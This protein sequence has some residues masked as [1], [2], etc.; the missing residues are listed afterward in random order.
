[1]NYDSLSHFV[2]GIHVA[3]VTHDGRQAK[4]EAIR[5]AMSAGSTVQP[6]L[7]REPDNPADPRAIAI[8]IVANCVRR[9]VGFLPAKLACDLSPLMDAGLEPVTVYA[10][11]VIGG[12]LEKPTLGMII[13]LAAR[14]PQAQEA[15][16]RFYYETHY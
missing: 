15:L 13:R 6:I 3:G 5:A 11:L 4:L 8:D 14:M 10:P 1:M 9:H 7:R 2:F 12:T 16:V